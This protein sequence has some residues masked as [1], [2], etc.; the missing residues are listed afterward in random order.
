MSDN[1]FAVG[2]YAGVGDSGSDPNQHPLMRELITLLSQTRPWVRLIGVLVLIGA[3]FM[4]LGGVAMFLQPANGPFL[5]GLY[6]LM[7]VFYIY[8]GLCLN[9]YAS[10]IKEAET[11]ADMQHVVEAILQ[12]KKFWRFCGIMTAIVLV[13][14]LLIF[15]FVIIA[16]VAGAMM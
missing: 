5:G 3:A 2:G 14:Y 1:P 15:V 16:A 12:Q 4:L 10:A 11:S 8:P 9:R 7:S 6:I 13:I